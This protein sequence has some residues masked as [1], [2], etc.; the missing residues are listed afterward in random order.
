[1]LSPAS[2]P[3]TT[4][5]TVAPRRQAYTGAFDFA[6]KGTHT[7]T[8]WSKDVAGNVETG[9]GNSI[10]LKIDGIAPTTTVINPI[11]PASG[12]FVTSG[13]PV[14]FD[15]NDAESGIAATYYQIDGGAAKTYGEEFTAD[16]STGSHTITYWSVDLAGN[17]EAKQTTQVKAD[18]V[19]PT[20]IQLIAIRK[21]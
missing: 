8:Y 5:S 7:I 1:M 2:L 19:P 10:T 14:A 21:M 11:S 17:V 18:N 12:W 4:A 16:L 9:I 3:P 15:A 6:T 20:I 13:I